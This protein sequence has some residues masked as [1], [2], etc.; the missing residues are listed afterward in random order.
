VTDG[1]FRQP[2]QYSGD[3]GAG[4]RVHR[5]CGDEAGKG[6]SS[7]EARESV[8]S[9]T[10]HNLSMDEATDS[11][12]CPQGK[13]LSYEGKEQRHTQVSYRYRAQRSIARDVRS[14]ANAV[15]AIG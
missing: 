5:A 4:N 15:L 11:Y 9:I 8:H 3:E 10:A 7:Y 13:T 12:R 14:K 6:K 2:G 1:G